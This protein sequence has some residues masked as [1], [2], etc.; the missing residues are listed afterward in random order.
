MLTASVRKIPLLARLA[1]RVMSLPMPTPTMPL[2]VLTHEFFPFRGGI[3]VYA[4]ETARAAAAMGFSVT[5]WAPDRPELRERPWPFAVR[6]VPMRGTLGWG[7]RLA[8]ARAI[9]AARRE[10]AQ[11]LVWLPEP[12]ALL[13]AMY[14]NALGRLPAQKL[15]LTLHGSEILR[16]AGWP[17][18]RRLFQKLLDRADRVGV[19]SEFNRELLRGRFRVEQNKIVLVSGALRGDFPTMLSPR[20]GKAPGAPVTLLTV[21]RVHPRKGQHCVLEALAQMNPRPQA[22]LEYVI[23]GPV[24][25]REYQRR[26]EA[27][28]KNCGVTVKFL[29]GVPDA[30]LPAVYAQA[31]IFVMTPV[32]HGPSVEGFGLVYLEA[33]AAGLPAI[34]HRTGGV[35]EAVRDGVTGLLAEPDD[36]AGLGAAIR[37]LAD[38]APKRAELAAAGQWRAKELS[39]RKNVEALFGGWPGT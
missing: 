6:P 17:H 5:V 22:A 16:F 8:L 23:A 20:A 27:L 3:A 9:G 10:L 12:G 25:K 31:D 18:R 34:A 39:W 37:L 21:G 2:A 38:N 24:V 32:P 19:V 7:C 26:L 15:V 29:G 36:R 1:Y 28:A 13:T 4:E 33:A 11:S 35:A 30:A 14:L